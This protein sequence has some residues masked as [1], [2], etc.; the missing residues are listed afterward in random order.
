MRPDLTYLGLHFN[1]DIVNKFCEVDEK[2]GD[3][4]MN[5]FSFEKC[6]LQTMRTQPL[7][8]KDIIKFYKK[9]DKLKEGLLLLNGVY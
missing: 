7:Y 3:L 6:V 1:E 2:D 4:K 8:P 5:Y 9:I